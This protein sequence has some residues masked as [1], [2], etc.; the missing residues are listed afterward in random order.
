MN[1]NE[2]TCEIVARLQITKCT[3]END[4]HQ[5]NKLRI[6][7]EDEENGKGNSI[8]L[9]S[10]QIAKLIAL[11]YVAGVKLELANARLRKT[12]EESTEEGL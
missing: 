3:D 12:K 4:T 8:L 7:L 1:L 6:L 11:L 2:S 5:E 10:N 9:D